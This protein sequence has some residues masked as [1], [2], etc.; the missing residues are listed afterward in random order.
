MDK[1]SSNHRTFRR[2][3]R[4]FLSGLREF[5]EY[6]GAFIVGFL[7]VVLCYALLFLSAIISFSY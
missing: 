7:L 1:I 2:L 4:S 6:E 3:Y 5:W